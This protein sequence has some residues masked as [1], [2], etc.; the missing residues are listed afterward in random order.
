MILR[1]R[2]FRLNEYTFIAECF[3]IR[4]GKVSVTLCQQPLSEGGSQGCEAEDIPAARPSSEDSACT[5]SS[6]ISYDFSA[7]LTMQTAVRSPCKEKARKIEPSPGPQEVM[8]R[9]NSNSAIPTHFIR[10]FGV[11]RA[12]LDDIEVTIFNYSLEV[13]ALLIIFFVQYLFD[14]LAAKQPAEIKVNSGTE[15]AELCKDPEIRK[16]LRAHSLVEKVSNALN[17]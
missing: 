5:A 4:Y 17:L 11:E 3:L 12:R 6:R 13:V 14:G 15:L 10:N 2:D 9:H 8:S 16:A 7:N 1:S